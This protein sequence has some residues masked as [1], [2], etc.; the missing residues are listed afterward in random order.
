MT[1]DVTPEIVVEDETTDETNMV[2]DTARKAML[3]GFG[4]V[5][6]TQDVL[7]EGSKSVGSLFDKLVE[8]GEEMEKDGREWIAEIRAQEEEV[9]EEEPVVE[10]A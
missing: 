3:V 2:F 9:I 1:N 6:M 4:V 7:V 10:P 5:G 8:R